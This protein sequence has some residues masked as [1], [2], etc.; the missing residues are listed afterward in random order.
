MP[1]RGSPC[2]VT[3]PNAITYIEKLKNKPRLFLFSDSDRAIPSDW[4]HIASVRTGVPPEG[5]MSELD[6]WLRQY[7]D[8][9]LVVDMRIGVV[10]PAIPNLEE[11]LRTFPR[12]VLIL[13]SNDTAAHQ[14]PKWEFPL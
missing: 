4:G 7:P 8:A 10:P 1:M 9:W 11:V 14:W 2:V 5:I 12:I 3:E 6:A 13:V